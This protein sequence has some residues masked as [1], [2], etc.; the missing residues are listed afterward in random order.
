MAQTATISPN[1]TYQVISGFG[2]H[3][4]PGWIPDLTAA[5]LHEDQQ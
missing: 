3:N 4:G 5:C 1:T 2:G